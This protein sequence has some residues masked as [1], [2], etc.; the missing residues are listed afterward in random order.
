MWNFGSTTK[1]NHATTHHSAEAEAALAYGLS[2]PEQSEIHRCHSLSDRQT[3]LHTAS[4]GERGFADMRYL[5]AVRVALLL[6]GW[7]FWFNIIR[8]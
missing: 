5:Q 3:Q 6:H 4:A 2:L 1:F 8:C 7:V